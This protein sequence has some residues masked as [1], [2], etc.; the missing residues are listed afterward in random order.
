[1]QVSNF[2]RFLTSKEGVDLYVYVCLNF[3]T[4]VALK[5]QNDTHAMRRTY[6][7]LDKIPQRTDRRR[8]IV[9]QYRCLQTMH[10]APHAILTHNKSRFF[11][12]P[13]PINIS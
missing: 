6:S 2:G 12:R 7:L 9:K 5:N 11:Y 4:A 3:E 8:E 10:A 1:M 13:T